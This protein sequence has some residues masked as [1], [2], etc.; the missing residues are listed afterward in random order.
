MQPTT[1]SQSTNNSLARARQ[2]QLL[3]NGD[4]ELLSHSR[5]ICDD[6]NNQKSRLMSNFKRAPVHTGA[7][8]SNVLASL[9]ATQMIDVKPV[10]PAEIISTI[11]DFLPIPDLMNFG[12][13]SKRML[14]MV[15]ED[16]RWVQR[17]QIMGVW[18]E[19]EAR[20]RFEEALR[21]KR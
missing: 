2:T 5:T 8:R 3:L 14:E 11:L 16:S 15:Y 17:L 20:K 7:P 6:I 13:T 9:K 1:T 19:G 12:R 4:A 10:L 18:N 21:M